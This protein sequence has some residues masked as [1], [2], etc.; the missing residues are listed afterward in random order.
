MSSSEL[1][2][3][4]G[5]ELL[6]EGV[7]AL[8]AKEVLSVPLLDLNVDIDLALDLAAPIDLAVA[9]NA[10]VALPADASV[11][12]NILSALSS[13]GALAKQGILLDQT[14]S[15]EA[16][17]HAHQDSAIDQTNDVVDDGG[18][19]P[20]CRRTR[21]RSPSSRRVPSP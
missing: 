1:E 20:A 8:P 21:S 10:N 11:S 17:A 14:I 12:T 15:G 6:A 4:A 13:A 5:A 2:R 18:S 7:S 16:V 3:L 9:A 19:T